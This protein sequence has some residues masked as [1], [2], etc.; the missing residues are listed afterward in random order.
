ME[1]LDYEKLFKNNLYP[2]Y[3]STLRNRSTFLYSEE[4][5]ENQWKSL[6][7]LKQIQWKKLKALIK[8]SYKNV[9][10]YRNQWD[11]LDINPK[12]IRSMS[13][14]KKL[15][16]L[17]KKDIQDN[18]QNLI[19][20]NFINRT[21]TKRTGGSTGI[22]MSF[23]FNDESDQRRSAVMWR[24]YRWAGADLGRKCIYLWG[25]PLGNDGIFSH[26][27]FE[28]FNFF[29]RR[30]I[31][32]S[33]N[34]STENIDSFVQKI[35]LYKPINIVAYVAPLMIIAKYTKDNG[36]NIEQPKSIITG[37]EALYDFQR[38]LLEDV[39]KCPVYNTYGC[40]EFMLISSECEKQNGLHINIDH[41]AAETIDKQGGEIN[42][43]PGKLV[44]TDL[45]NY[46]MPL[47]RYVNG[48]IAEL[49]DSR[50]S[51]G[52]GLPMMSSIQGRELDII[53]THDGRTIPGEF[54]PHLFK[55]AESVHE[56]QVLQT[57][58]DELKIYLVARNGLSDSD[59][60]F[61]LEKM[62]DT[63]G[64]QVKIRFKF[65]DR[66]PRTRSGKLRLT[67]RIVQGHP[68]ESQLLS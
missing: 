26:L 53:R 31:L 33:F 8:H 12:D 32:N 10:Y 66:I 64:E 42:G 62:R 2:F 37:A 17:N 43:K 50:C 4:Y 14:Y 49:N 15:P 6:D 61:L 47:I 40:R 55:E 7:E 65:I 16:L 13:D 19:A 20:R 46:G 44:I 18:Y 41:L 60:K 29:L 36:I 68:M 63:L 24:G 9:S 57:K 39:F 48:D 59:R 22:P 56:F 3:E 27:K 23:E 54:F 51:C 58:P 52:R 34:L 45:H 25:V 5:E 35:N 11:K 38:T 30:K 28:C 21:R 67:G 1:V